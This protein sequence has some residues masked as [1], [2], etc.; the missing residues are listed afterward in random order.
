MPVRLAWMLITIF[1]GVLPGII[2]YILSMFIIP[3]R[4]VIEGAVKRE[5]K[6]EEREK[7]EQD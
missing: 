7:V 6:T 5:E 3:E 1:T 4:P 2:I